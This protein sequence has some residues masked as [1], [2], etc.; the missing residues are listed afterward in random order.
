MRQ[1]GCELQA[2]DD[3]EFRT[4]SHV[5]GPI[6]AGFFWEKRSMLDFKKKTCK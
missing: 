6:S 4:T 2:A 1:A 3:D 5:S